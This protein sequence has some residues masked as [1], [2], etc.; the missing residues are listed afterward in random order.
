M[1]DI[2]L[3]PFRSESYD[4]E[5][6]WLSNHK[7]MIVCHEKVVKIPLP[8]GKVLRVIGERTEEKMRHL[9]S[10]RTKEKKQEE[11]V[12]VR[13]FPKVFPDDLSGLPPIQEIEF[14]IKLV[15]GAIPVAKSP[16][17]LAPFE[18]EEL[19][20]QLK[21]LQDKELNKLT[22][23]N[24]YPLPMIDDMFDQLQGSKY[25]SKIDLSFGY[26]QLRV[27]EDDIPKTTFRTRYGNFEFTAMPFGLTNAPATQ[28]EHEVHLGLILELLKEEKLYAKFSK[29]EF[30]LQ[31]VQFLEHVIN[32]VY[33]HRP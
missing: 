2:N 13:D 31:E 14:R 12:V 30:W 23:K 20:C 1:F 22:I 19:S 26:H 25:F 11:I 10:A 33:S 24:H 32:G 8:D 4:V 28:E 16:Y 3:I 21:E 5:M 7:A 17:R 6:D 29:C 15:P 9:M 18:I 27:H